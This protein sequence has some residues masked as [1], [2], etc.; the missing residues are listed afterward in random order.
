[1][2]KITFRV[3]AGLVASV[4]LVVFFNQKLP[5]FW[6]VLIY[7]LKMADE[8]AFWVP[9]ASVKLLAPAL[10]LSGNYIPRAFRALGQGY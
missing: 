8:V 2:K 1:M 7:G 5:A 3:Y 9:G 10:R 4:F 6:T